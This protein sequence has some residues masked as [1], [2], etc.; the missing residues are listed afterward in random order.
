M[1]LFIDRKFMTLVSPKLEKF[2]QKNDYIWNFRCPFCG[3][4]KKNKIKARGYV[5][6]KKN[7]LFFMCH[8]CSTSTSFGKFLKSIDPLLYKEYQLTRA[9]WGL[10]IFWILN[11]F[12]KKILLADY[13]AVNFIDRVFASPTAYTGFENLMAIYGYSLQEIG[14]AHV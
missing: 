7:D 6:R 1:A 8:N 12:I 4:S 3:D 5:Y 11:G 14:R 9:E 2:A 13:I 10:A